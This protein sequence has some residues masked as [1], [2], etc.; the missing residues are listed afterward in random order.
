MLVKGYTT[1]LQ[2]H[3]HVILLYPRVKSGHISKTDKTYKK[4]NTDLKNITKGCVVP[5]STQIPY[6]NLL[7][8]SSMYITKKWYR[9]LQNSQLSLY[10]TQDCFNND[11][12]PHVMKLLH[13]KEIYLYF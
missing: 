8:S 7:T 2:P 9:N 3:A 10:D 4:V 11:C 1:E 5:L 12:S 6:F 13:T